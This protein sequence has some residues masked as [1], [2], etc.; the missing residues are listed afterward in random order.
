MDAK[1]AAAH[2]AHAAVVPVASLFSGIGGIDLGLERGDAKLRPCLFC[3]VHPDARAVL[4]Q[5]YPD[6]PIH[7]DVRTLERLPPE[8]RVLTAGSPCCD[9]SVANAARAGMEGGKSSLLREVFRLLSDAPGITHVV[10]ENVANILYLHGGAAMREIAD[11][12]TALGFAFAYRVVDARAFGLRQRRRRMICVAQRGDQPPWWLVDRSVAPPPGRPAHLH[13]HVFAGFSWLDGHRGCGFEND[14]VP[15]L[16]AHDTLHLQSQPAIIVPATGHV[17]ILS[18]EDGEALQGFPVGW[19]SAVPARRR[20]AR[21][22]NAVPV[23]VFEWIG[24]HLLRPSEGLGRPRPDRRARRRPIAGYGAPGATLAPL[25]G[26]TEWPRLPR[27]LAPPPSALTPLSARALA[28]F[29]SRAR[30]GK[31]GMPAWAL[32]LVATALESRAQAG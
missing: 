5:H 15:T 25:A 4:M 27:A 22:G 24:E 32:Q 11:E 6:V 29:L 2:A 12:L 23:N 1:H 13:P 10:L 9:F 16:R 21:I 26:V 17:G 19:T 3:E 14:V 20:Y 28:G 8:A 31:P 7:A 18:I 30:R